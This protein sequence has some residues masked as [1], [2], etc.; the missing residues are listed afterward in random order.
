MP[1]DEFLGNLA[2]KLLD[3]LVRT[4]DGL[5]KSFI[6]DLVIAREICALAVRGK[7]HKDLKIRDENHWPLVVAALDLHQLLDPGHAHPGQVKWIIR[8]TCLNIR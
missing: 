3:L 6:D 1:G 2:A 8:L 7:I 5:F 4:I